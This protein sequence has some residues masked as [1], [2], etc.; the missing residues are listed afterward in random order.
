ML[1][2]LASTSLC[3]LCSLP[4]TAT[5]ERDGPRDRC[6]HSS[7]RALGVCMCDACAGR[8][9]KSTSKG[10]VAR[11][12]RRRKALKDQEGQGRQGKA[13]ARRGTRHSEAS[14]VAG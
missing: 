3:C 2:L 11:T 7:M 1:I 5:P 10:V 14:R 4:P 8:E 6:V 13:D 12:T 9:E